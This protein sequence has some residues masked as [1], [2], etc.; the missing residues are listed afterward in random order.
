MIDRR[1]A[2]E[3]L[4]AAVFLLANFM[5]SLFAATAAAIVAAVLAVFLRY[6]IDGQL[7]FLAIA[8]VAL[9]VL[10]LGIGFS[11]DNENF[12]KVRP[13]IGGIAFALILAAGSLFRPSLLQR[14]LGYKLIITDWGWRILHFAWMGIALS[15][16][17]VNELVWRNTSTDAWVA[18][19]SLSGPLVFGI[20]F[21][22][23]WTVA[24]FF[25]DED[26][27][28]EEAV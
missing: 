5:W 17:L 22:A 14:S 3:F 16:A 2:L 20:Y 12:I 10:M 8:T 7:P 24:W 6:R 15:L 19:N 25:W 4:P 26:D 11:Q 21:A 27:E 23:T 28:E 18:Y 1:L 9:S 13:T